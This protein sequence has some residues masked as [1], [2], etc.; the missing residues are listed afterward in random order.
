MAEPATPRAG[1]AAHGT[2]FS[3][4]GYTRAKVGADASGRLF[5]VDVTAAWCLPCKKMDVTTW[6]DARIVSWLGAHAVAVQ[7]DYDKERKRA[8]DFRAQQL[9]TVIVFKSGRELDRVTGYQSPDQLL[10]WLEGVHSRQQ[11]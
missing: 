8:L 9:P 6:A 11:G 2:A 4:L 3:D 5:V 10:N 7:V 1:T